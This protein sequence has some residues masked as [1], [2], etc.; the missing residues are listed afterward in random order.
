M[1]YAFEV[2][3]CK[4]RAE[5]RLKNSFGAFIHSS[6]V[7]HILATSGKMWG[8]NHCEGKSLGFLQL[9]SIR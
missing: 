3:D 2:Q 5:T 7:N 8:A 6:H 9:V 1:E 4:K